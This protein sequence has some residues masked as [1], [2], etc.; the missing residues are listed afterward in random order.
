MRKSAGKMKP[1]AGY[2]DSTYLD[3]DITS[4]TSA[5]S[6]EDFEDEDDMLRRSHTKTKMKL[7]VN[8]RR[9][10]SPPSPQLSPIIYDQDMDKLTDDESSGLF[11]RRMPRKKNLLLQFNVPLGYH[12]PL[13]VK[14]D[15]TMLDAEE[16]GKTHEMHHQEIKKVCVKSLSLTPKPA[17]SAGTGFTDL[18]PEMRNTVYRY[19][20]LRSNRDLRIPPWRD[21]EC[22]TLSAQFLRT[23]KLVHHEGCSILYG[24]NTFQFARHFGTR[25]PFWE[26]IPKEIGYQDVLQFLKMIGAE[27]L[28]YLRDIK[29]IFDDA[30]PRDTPYLNCH[31]KRRYLNDDYLMNCLRIL[32]NAKLR[33][34]LLRFIGRR[35]VMK[36]DVKFL[37]YLE[38]IKADHVDQYWD[39][40]FHYPPQKICFGTWLDL[41][42]QMTRK[43]RLYQK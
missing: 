15:S 36:T 37:G 31:E 41:Q 9:S 7:K 22:L 2:V 12:G 25:G 28:Q 26:R 33:T 3:D 42:D 5:S 34:L 27:N 18:P 14:V 43:K 10:P 20:F 30:L 16:E 17:T 39:S 13:I 29:F 19:L 4:A 23:C 1:I 21:G 38:Q 8:P 6:E 35:A 24:E 11:H 32:R 40:D